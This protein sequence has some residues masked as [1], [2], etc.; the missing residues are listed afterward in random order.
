MK[1]LLLLLLIIAYLVT[2]QDSLLYV[3]YYLS[4]TLWSSEWRKS[5]WNITKEK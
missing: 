2:R 1:L 4:A 5:L 3:L